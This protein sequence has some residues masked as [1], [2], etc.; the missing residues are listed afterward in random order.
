MF[1]SC[2]NSII[3]ADKRKRKFSVCSVLRFRSKSG[4]ECGGKRLFGTGVASLPYLL[5]LFAGG[6]ALSDCYE[7]VERDQMCLKLLC[8]A[9]A[10]S[11]SIVLIGLV[12][13]GI[14]TQAAFIA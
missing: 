7:F 6:N 2:L 13:V 1:Y 14:N 12:H 11:Q 9:I 4:C 10:D 5:R 3:H 8:I